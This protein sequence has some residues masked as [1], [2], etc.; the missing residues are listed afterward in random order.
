MVSYLEF[1]LW[2]SEIYFHPSVPGQPLNLSVK[3][4]SSAYLIS[5]EP[6]TH[7]NGVILDYEVFYRAS[8]ISLDVNTKVS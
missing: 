1:V 2:F 5:W 8:F 7:P 6:P 4:I 3:N